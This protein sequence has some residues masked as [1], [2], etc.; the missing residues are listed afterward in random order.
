MIRTMNK[1]SRIL[2]LT[3]LFTL[4][5]NMNSFSQDSTGVSS[6]NTTSDS[7]VQDS[8]PSFEGYF[9]EIALFTG[10]SYN[11]GNR[12]N[13]CSHVFELGVW[14]AKFFGHCESAN[15]NYYVASDF[16]FH[17]SKFAIGPKIGAYV[18]IM[19]FCAGVELAYYSN[20]KEDTIVFIPYLG[21]GHNSLKLTVKSNLNLSNKNFEYINPFSVSFSNQIIE[22]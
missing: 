17:D 14:R 4:F 15:S 9:K 19:P 11:F 13:G 21:M 22:A 5:W 6:N 18:G 20:F 3:L 12:P 10:Y 7:L 8:I 16:V 2:F 1:I